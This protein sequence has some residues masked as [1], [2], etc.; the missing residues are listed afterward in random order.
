MLDIVC[1]G[2]WMIFVGLVMLCIGIALILTGKFIPYPR[3]IEMPIVDRKS[4]K[5]I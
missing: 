4:G 5:H 2:E 3:Y 1:I